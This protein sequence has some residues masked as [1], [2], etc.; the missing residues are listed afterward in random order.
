MYKSRVETFNQVHYF[1]YLMF[2]F[3]I[4]DGDDM[5]ETNCSTSYEQ[6]YRSGEGGGRTHRLCL[7]RN[8]SFSGGRSD[9]ILFH[10]RSTYSFHLK[11][12]VGPGFEPAD[13]AGDKSELHTDSWTRNKHTATVSL[14][15]QLHDGFQRLNLQRWAQWEASWFANTEQTLSICVCIGYPVLFFKATQRATNHFVS[16]TS[17][18]SENRTPRFY[19]QGEKNK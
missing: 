17:D 1:H 9:V 5:K 19:L 10:Q 15:L 16:V 6:K 4:Q 14:L 8:G 7:K 11:T 2:L 12:S 18:I 3:I 13:Q